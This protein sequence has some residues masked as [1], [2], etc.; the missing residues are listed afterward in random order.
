MFF[1][2]SIKDGEKSFRARISDYFHPANVSVEKIETEKLLPFYKITAVRHR[3]EIPWKEI[4]NAAGRFCHRAIMNV[5]E[6]IPESSKIKKY[7]PVVFPTRILFNS[8]V[9]V[10]EK[11]K[12]DPIKMSIT[13]FDEN[14][15]LTDMIENL[16]K[17]CSSIRI[18]TSCVRDYE[19]VR[20]DLLLKY[21]IS[22]II[23]PKTDNIILTSTAIISDKS[24]DIPLIYHGLLFTNERRKMLNASVLCGKNITLPD[25]IKHL[26]DP[27]YDK[28]TF[29]SAL[30]ELCSAKILE[31][32]LYDDMQ[33]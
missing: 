12:L 5:S 32:T 15:Y 28:L 26:F 29:A 27:G 31:K 10:L 6:N 16:V 14:G 17:L 22:V 20:D 2:L 21:G 18:V 4:E 1:L 13:V 8:A 30:Y 3:G 19:A 23:T 24:G 11:L 25:E 9:S 33:V 7:E